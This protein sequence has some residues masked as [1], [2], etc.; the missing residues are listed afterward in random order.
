MVTVEQLRQFA[1]KAPGDDINQLN[2]AMDEFGIDTPIRQAMFLA[3]LCVECIEFTTFVEIW[4][5]GNPTVDQALYQGRHGNDRPGDGYL[6]RGRGGIQVTFADNYRACGADIGVDLYNRP[7]LAATPEQRYRVSG[8]Y[9]RSRN[10]NQFADAGDTT[11]T[12]KL[13]NGPGM[14]GL[15]QRDAYF[16]KACQVLGVVL[17]C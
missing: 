3:Q 8:W 5:P 16:Q 14:Y 4:E 2:A 17:A 7:E 9:W 10:L 13:I 1:P 6:F 12:T 11:T 15:K